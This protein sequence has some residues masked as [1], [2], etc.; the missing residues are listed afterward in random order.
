MQI[1]QKSFI[2]PP[3][4][5]AR[6][7]RSPLERAKKTVFLAFSLAQEADLLAL[8]LPAF[9]ARTTVINLHPL[10]PIRSGCSPR[11]NS[12]ALRVRGCVREHDVS[13]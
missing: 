6:R 4:S 8:A 1:Y 10:C 13:G 11:R 12:A 5:L 2:D 7:M 3:I 9:F